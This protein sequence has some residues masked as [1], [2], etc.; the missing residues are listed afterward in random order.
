MESYTSKK[1]R[2]S[3]LIRDTGLFAI[4]FFG[5]KVIIFLLTPLLTS[6]LTTEEY[7]LADL[8]STTVNFIY[9]IL[10]LAIAD[11]TLRFAMEK[12]SDK[13]A[14]LSNSLLITAISIAIG[15][16]LLPLIK[17]VKPE[18]WNYSVIF[19]TIY[20]L[21]NIH[22]CLSNFVKSIGKTK[23]FAIQGVLQAFSIAIC[24]VVFLLLF[25]MGL[26]GYLLSIIIGYSIPILF[27]IIVGKLGKYIFPFHVNGKLLLQM[28]RY[29]IPMVPTL[30]AWAAN[31]SIDKYMILYLDGL[32]S[33][34][35][36][37]VAHKIPTLF[38]SVATVFV[39][40]WQL[41]AISN[42]GSN[43]E[44]DFHTRVYNGLNIF[45]LLLC[46]GIVS[47]SKWFASFLFAKDFFKAWIFVP[48]LTMSAMFASHGGF[49]ASE[50]RA[51]KKTNSLF[52]SVIVGSV[53][54]IVLNYFLIL[55]YGSLGAAVATAISFTIIW[56]FR[57]ILIQRIVKV[58]VNVP[59]TILNY[60]LFVIETI[61]V[62]ADWEQSTIASFFLILLIAIINAKEIKMIIAH[63]YK[64]FFKKKN[65]IA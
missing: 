15:A 9:P 48:L 17:Y 16:S 42:Y 13:N 7:G 59:L 20:S 26:Y 54:N 65:K 28:L 36:Y 32:S 12:E 41:S 46:M 53:C 4:S 33:S 37:S 60:A 21:F 25:K 2:A 50:F 8:I 45:S 39:Q 23:L 27:M 31:T 58:K 49:L 44:S 40:A 57:I 61:I 10:T 1:N 35:V 47:L 56:M 51:A 64:S 24:S 29:S 5:S 14:V 38:T 52:L 3:T 19:L 30:L 43:D 63:F 34:G 18:L 62:M 55:F 6:I 22:N 11:A